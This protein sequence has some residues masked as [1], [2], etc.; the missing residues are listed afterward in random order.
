[1]TRVSAGS[2]WAALCAALLAGGCGSL[3]P[4]GLADTPPVPERAGAEVALAPSSAPERPAAVSLPVGLSP[5]TPLTLGKVV[6]IALECNPVTRSSYLQARSAAASLGIARAAYYPTIEAAGGVARTRQTNS[7]RGGSPETVFSA[8]LGLRYLLLDLG[9]RAA[10]A[11]EARLGLIAADYSHNAV[12]RGVALDVEQAYFDYCNARG[13]REA[14]KATVAQAQTALDAADLR[15][16]AGVATIAEVL[17]AKTALSQAKLDLERVEGEVMVVRG[18]LAT[19]MG[20]PADTPYDVSG[21]PPE[22]PLDR[23]L[24]A[25]EEFIATAKSWRPDL[26]AARALA[27]ASAQRIRSARARGLPSISLFADAARTYYEPGDAAD[28]GD[29]WSLGATLSVPLFTGFRTGYEIDKALEEAE[30]AGSRAET[31]EQRV[32]L[33]VW[34]S[35]YA[36][37]TAVE[38][39]KASRDVLASA[40]QAERVALGRYKEGVGTLI[41]LLVN[42]SVLA[43]A[44]AQEVRARAGWCIA[45]ARLAHDAG[46]VVPIDW[47]QLSLEPTRQS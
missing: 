28:H 8:G 42:Q 25:V 23:S 15:H 21:L 6:D 10:D 33:Q 44:R 5:D 19:T 29:S 7:Q 22:V 20:L 12:V 39:V 43:T 17:Q 32:V 24:A 2:A 9:G 34:T 18:L 41:D 3:V 46:L 27:E 1:M 36:L 35:Y 13:Q 14:A 4:R 30:L 26:A 11:D 45:L 40:E 38:I 16:N 37:R 31:L 47:N